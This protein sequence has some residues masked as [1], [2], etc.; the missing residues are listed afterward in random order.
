MVINLEELDLESLKNLQDGA[1]LKQFMALME[2][3]VRDIKNRPGDERSR[4][5][6]LSFELSPKSEWIEDPADDTRKMIALRGVGLKIS[7]DA[8]LPSRHTVEYDCGVN[9]KDRLVFNPISPLNHLAPTLPFGNEEGTVQF[10][11]VGGGTG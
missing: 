10:R 3:A 6:V 2:T 5:V 7:M 9:D 1:A 4:K 8:K 11:N